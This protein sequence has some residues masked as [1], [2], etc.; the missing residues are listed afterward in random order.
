MNPGNCLLQLAY[1]LLK[2]VAIQKWL[3]EKYYLHT[4]LYSTTLLSTK[5]LKLVHEY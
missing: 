1:W 2:V 3:G 5:L 4:V